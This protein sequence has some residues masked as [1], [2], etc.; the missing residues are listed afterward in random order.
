MNRRSR[1]LN[2]FKRVLLGTRTPHRVKISPSPHEIRNPSYLFLP[3]SLFFFRAYFSPP[4][5]FL[6]FERSPPPP[7]FHSI[8]RYVRILIKFRF[9]ESWWSRG[10]VRASGSKL[11]TL[12]ITIHRYSYGNGSGDGGGGGGLLALNQG[13]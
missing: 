10:S 12:G 6:F 13:K 3:S 9:E 5:F 7:F 4:F 11:Q 1:Q 2:T 8:P